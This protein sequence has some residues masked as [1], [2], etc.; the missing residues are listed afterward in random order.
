[1]DDIVAEAERLAQQ[2]AVELNLIAQDLC[3][4]GKDLQPNQSLAQLL[5]ALNRV[6]EQHDRPLWI[7]CLYAYPRGLTRSVVAA[8]AASEHV[9]PYLDLPLQHISD[10][11]LRRMR[12]GKGGQATRDLLAR[13]RAAVPNLTLRTT[14]I[15]GLP[16]ETDDAFAEL[17][18]FVEEMRFER[19]GVFAYSPEE[20]TEAASFSGQ[21][22]PEVAAWRRGH[23]LSLQQRIS[24][25]QQH[26]LIGETLDVLV[27]GVSD[28]TDLLLKGR[29]AGQAPDIDGVTYINSGTASP[30]QVV[31]VLV[32]QAHDYDLVGG[33]VD[34]QPPL[35]FS[36]PKAIDTRL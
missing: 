19:L 29:H 3:A 26:D 36:E 27:E 18:S 35:F 24:R 33:I 12:R 10:G 28:E 34:P 16:G 22:E 1:V 21:V 14:F 17:C 13:L 30:G 9:L 2:G 6:G 20:D 7:R 4:Y 32:D 15:T 25:E 8:M 23:L 5:R 31:Q 11:L